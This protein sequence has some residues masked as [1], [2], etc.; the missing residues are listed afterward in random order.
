MYN[1]NSYLRHL[2][3]DT[4][5]NA[6]IENFRDLIPRDL[7]VSSLII[8]INFFLRDRAL[9]ATNIQLCAKFQISIS[10]SFW[11]KRLWQTDGRTDGHRSDCISV[12]FFYFLRRNTKKLIMIIR[13]VTKRSRGMRWRKFSIRALCVESIERCLKYEFKLYI[14]FSG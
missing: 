3:I 9:E 10:Y 13:D 11:E 4:I 14:T 12:P 6:L 2:S 5:H 1:L 8:K 7:F